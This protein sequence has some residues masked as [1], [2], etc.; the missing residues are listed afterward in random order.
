MQERHGG[1]GALVGQDLGV[2]EPGVVVQEGVQVAVAQGAFGAGG[3]LVFLALLLPGGAPS[4]AVGDVAEFLDV[5]VGQLAG[6]GALVPADRDAG[7]PVQ[8]CQLRAAVPGQ[9]PVHR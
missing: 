8:V 7:G 2:G 4:A 1:G 3:Q 6:P 9:H 5:D